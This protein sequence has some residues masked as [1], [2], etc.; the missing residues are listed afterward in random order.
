RAALNAPLVSFD[1]DKVPTGSLSGR[2]FRKLCELCMDPQYGPYYAAGLLNHAGYDL[3]SALDGAIR[4][5]QEEKNTQEL[6]LRGSGSGGYD[7][8]VMQCSADFYHH[9][10]KK[11][12][13]RYAEAVRQWY[14]L[15]NRCNECDDL[16]ATLRGLKNELSIL[17]HDFFAPLVQLLDDLN[18]TFTENLR[19]LDSD[20]A[21][22]SPYTRHILALKEVRP[23]LDEVVAQLSPHEVVSKFVTHLLKCYDQWQ[24]QEDDKIA[25]YII[26]YME[27]V[28]A[29]Q[30]NRS[31]D[32]YL[33]DVYPQ[34]GGNACQLAE[35]IERD[36][37]HR[38][39]D[40]A[41]PMFWCN[42]T[43]ALDNPAV[44]F[45]ASSIS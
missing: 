11:N 27:T 23:K 39:H 38:I 1:F 35:E 36:I 29:P 28:F 7:E 4:Q 26:R 16:A 44:T 42:P 20:A 37:I 34:A 40:S 31:L 45:Q 9:T 8:Y 33:M 24:D 10:N 32:D 17:Y 2:I 15:Y 41:L 6:Q 5:A 13:L 18:E 22:P 14:L 30:V 43:F 3:M 25:T 21:A 19:Y 12:Y